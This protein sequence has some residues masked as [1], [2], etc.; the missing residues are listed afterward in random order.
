MNYIDRLYSS[1]F[2]YLIMMVFILLGGAISGISFNAFIMPHKLLSG[3]VSGIALIINY[4]T[5]IKVIRHPN[6]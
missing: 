6:I 2:K 4:L 3:G 5:G 1:K